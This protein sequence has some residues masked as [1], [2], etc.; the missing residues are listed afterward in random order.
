[1]GQQSKTVTLSFTDYV[2]LAQV[3]EFELRVKELHELFEDHP[4]FYSADV[5]RH[6]G[7][8]Q[9]EYTVLVRFADSDSAE[10][11]KKSPTI[12]NKLKEVEAITGGAVR[13]SKCV[14]L[15]MWVDHVS[16]ITSKQPPFWKQLVLS[17]LGVYPTL[18]VL[19]A[20][21]APL[22]NGLPQLLGVFVTVTLL[23]ALLIN[24]VMPA[25]NR[26]LDPW[27]SR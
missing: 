24:P 5:V 2:P 12:A 23:S 9:M 8:Q 13:T 18:I 10:R 15:G 20:V 22:L 16:G 26:L 19:M 4:G 11:R 1:M 25:L 27:L 17:F 3:S 7:A 6:A 14:G 21:T